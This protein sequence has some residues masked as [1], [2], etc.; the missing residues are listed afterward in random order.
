MIDVTQIN[1]AQIKADQVT[2]R[3]E[4]T[5]LVK[6]HGYIKH[7]FNESQRNA[8]SMLGNYYVTG[9]PIKGLNPKDSNL[10]LRNLS[11]II[12]IKMRQGINGIKPY[13]PNNQFEKYYDT[14]AKK[15][16]T[17]V[18]NSKILYPSGKGSIRLRNEHLRPHAREFLDKVRYISII[19]EAL[20]E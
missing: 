10:P 3:L 13:D 17:E 14:A 2:S 18:V 7:C 8:N 15:Y 5:D 11:E 1:I 9:Q 6:Q 4:G 12:E 19:G 20:F 16:E